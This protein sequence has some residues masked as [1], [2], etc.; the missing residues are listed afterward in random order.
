M[1]SVLI[2]YQSIQSIRANAWYFNARNTLQQLS[3]PVKSEELTAA[4]HA[5]RL[6]TTIEPKHPHYWHFY[7]YIKMRSIENLRLSSDEFELNSEHTQ[8]AYTQAEHAFLKSLELRQAWAETWVALAQVVS[9]R[10]GPNEHV[11]AYLQ[12]A[13]QVGPFELNVHLGIIQIVL[14]HWP[15]LS[16]KY[17]ALYMSELKLAASYGYEF[18]R[19]FDIAL[20][21]NNLA[22]L[23]LSL[24]FGT[25][26]ESI[27][28]AQPFKRHCGSRS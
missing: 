19:V 8:L 2:I 6:A 1:F 18:N 15:N 13:K 17:K 3:S 10:Q 27:R 22:I 7:G 16:P 23:C 26:F 28:A 11:Y 25:A 5:I 14:A 4:E 21:S 24:Q 9:Y 20:Q 12:R